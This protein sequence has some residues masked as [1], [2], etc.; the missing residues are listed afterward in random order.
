MASV[1]R[2]TI[3]LKKKVSPSK[4]VR[5][6]RNRKKPN[7]LH[8]WFEIHEKYSSELEKIKDEE[9]DDEDVDKVEKKSNTTVT[10][11]ATTVKKKS[12][13]EK[14]AEKIGESEEEKEKAQEHQ[15]L[16]TQLSELDDRGRERK[17]EIDEECRQRKKLID[18]EMEKEKEN[19]RAQHTEKLRVIDEKYKVNPSQA[20]AQDE[21]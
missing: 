12:K 1:G 6:T 19:L 2:M 20:V 10:S 17:K 13:K 15:R 9:E 11:N 18:D 5:L 7:N 4:W 21:L 16:K 3:N 14:R 8:Y